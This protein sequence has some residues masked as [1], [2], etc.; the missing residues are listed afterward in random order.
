MSRVRLTQIELLH[1][2]LS[3][4]ALLLRQVLYLDGAI[5]REAGFVSRSKM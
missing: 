1:S 5:L 3:S 4:L 2:C